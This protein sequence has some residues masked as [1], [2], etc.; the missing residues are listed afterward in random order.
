MRAFIGRLA[1][2]EPGFDVNH[3]AQS[4]D[5]DKAFFVPPTKVSYGPFRLLSTQLLLLEGEKPVP[6]GSRA[7][8]IPISFLER[9]GELISEQDLVVRVWPNPTRGGSCRPHPQATPGARKL[10]PLVLRET[11]SRNHTIMLKVDRHYR[12]GSESIEPPRR[13][14]NTWEATLETA[15][16]LFRFRR[17]RGLRIATVCAVVAAAA[18]LDSILTAFALAPTS[19]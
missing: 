2:P 19:V 5:T 1:R 14:M 7:L 10:S 17:A 12:R 13:P 11:M 6:R 8:E 3:A 16:G 4:P 18:A 15:V 9:R